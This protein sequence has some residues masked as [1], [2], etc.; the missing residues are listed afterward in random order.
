MDF[1]FH[2]QVTAS[3]GAVNHTATV[4]AGGKLIKTLTSVP[5][6]LDQKVTEAFGNHG[7]YL[8]S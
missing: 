4:S 1:G 6:K 5:M 7:G 3:D 2:A 8:S